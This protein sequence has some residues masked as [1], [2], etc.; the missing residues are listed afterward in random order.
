MEMKQIITAT[1]AVILI[2]LVAIPLIDGL[3][4]ENV[5]TLRNNT[6]ELFFVTE[7]EDE[8]IVITADNAGNYKINGESFTSTGLIAINEG[9][10]INYSG[11][12]L[13]IRNFKDSTFNYD[14]STLLTSQS[15]TIQDGTVTTSTGKS[16]AY[17]GPVLYKSEKG[18]YGQTVYGQDYYIDN[19]SII[20]TDIGFNFGTDSYAT[21][22][23]VKGTWQDMKVSS[24][25]YVNE[26]TVLDPADFTVEVMGITQDTAISGLAKSTGLKVTYDNGVESQSGTAQKTRYF[27][28]PIEYHTITEQ[29]GVII[30][31]LQLIPVLLIASLVLGIGYSIA[32]RE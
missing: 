22:M 24:A 11:S 8:P 10:K 5:N 26:K 15:V 6:T 2:C 16:F 20:Y 12:N 27:W 32:R 1:V 25:I 18:T 17:T 3:T 28:A 19:D 31:I 29:Q 4:T 23:I 14:E 30:T 13:Q 9:F 21:E 7:S